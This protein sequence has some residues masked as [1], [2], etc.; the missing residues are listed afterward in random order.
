MITVDEYIGQH[1]AGHEEELTDEIRANAEILCGRA[2]QLI[3]EFGE[4]RG[5]RSGWRPAAINKSAG[6]AT[7]SRHMTGQAIDVEDDDGLLDAFCRQNIIL[8]EQLELWLEDG[9]ATP[10]WCHVQCV[11]PRSG[12]RFFIP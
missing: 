11:P 8:L 12:R 10:T 4:D 3:A 2:N 7:R 9:A 1:I 6:G 5:L